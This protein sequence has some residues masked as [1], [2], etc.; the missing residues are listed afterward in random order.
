MTPYWEGPRLRAQTTAKTRG[1]EKTAPCAMASAATWEPVFENPRSEL[2]WSLAPVL[3]AMASLGSVCATNSLAG[4]GGPGRK[5]QRARRRRQDGQHGLV[6]SR[7][8]FLC[9]E[10]PA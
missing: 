4:E 3:A 9:I 6:Q 1:N 2:S 8:R 5:E 10:Q 7:H